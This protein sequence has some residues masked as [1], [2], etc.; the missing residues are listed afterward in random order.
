MSQPTF[1]VISPE[2]TRDDALNMILASIA[3]EELGLSHIINAEGEKLQYVLGTLPK[4]DGL[5]AGVD[6]VIAVNDSIKCLLDSV[7]QNQVFLKAK[8]EKVLNII[9]DPVPGPT[10]PTGPTGPAGA[11]GAAGPAGPAGVTG[12]TGPT[13]PA[14]PTGGATGSTGA[15]GATGVTG[16]TGIMGPTG[17]TGAPG[18][19]GPSGGIQC[20]AGFTVS[21]GL[22]W[23]PGC[24]LPWIYLCSDS[25]KICLDPDSTKI[26]LRCGRCYLVSFA[27][28]VC[29][30]RRDPCSISVAL[31]TMDGCD[32]QDVFTYR[33][34]TYPA[35]APVTASLGGIVISTC[36]NER[37]TSLMLTLQSANLVQVEKAYLSIMEI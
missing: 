12:P 29:P 6:Q 18:P 19:P 14:G 34:P 35:G 15:T 22:R 24:P 32:R 10:G 27:V 4:R 5:G 20:A 28:N 23:D 3:M 26:I 9:R 16:A 7:M 21:P 25:C 33:T 1:P 17:A 11:T 36:C 8:A 30:L 13:G 37:D 31:Q 2:I